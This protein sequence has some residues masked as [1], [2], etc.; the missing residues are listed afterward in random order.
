MGE[1]LFNL[2]INSGAYSCA[3]CHTQ[4]WSYQSPGVPGQGRSVGT[5]PVGRRT[6]TSPA[7]KT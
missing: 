7:S 5:S 2:D 1:A 4:G 6:R 3:R